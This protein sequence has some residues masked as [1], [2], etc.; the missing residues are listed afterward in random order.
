MAVT[1]NL[2]NEAPE[3]VPALSEV[4]QFRPFLLTTAPDRVKAAVR[5]PNISGGGT[6]LLFDDSDGLTW[7]NANTQSTRY[8][9]VRY[10]RPDE[11]VTI[12]G[13]TN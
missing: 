10:L 4:V 5:I 8:T 6:L 11:S 1:V 13:S 7:L 9:F 12:A 3:K 2:T